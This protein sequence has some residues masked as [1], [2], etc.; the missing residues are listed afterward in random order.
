MS[1]LCQNRISVFCYLNDLTVMFSFTG[2]GIFVVVY[3]DQQD[4]TAAIPQG[5]RILLMENLVDGS[6]G[7]LIPFQFDHQRRPFGIMFG[8]IHHIRI[9]DTGREFF[10]LEIVILIGVIGKFDHASQT[11]LFVVMQRGGLFRMDLFTLCSI[12]FS[13]SSRPADAYKLLGE[14]LLHC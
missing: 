9:S 8:Q 3:S 5:I 11:G 1:R 2:G 10:P 12:R 4:I 14:G 7:G 13:E 6:L